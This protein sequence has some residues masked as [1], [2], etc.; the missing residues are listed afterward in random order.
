MYEI[1]QIENKTSTTI[2][3]KRIKHLK[4]LFTTQNKINSPLWYFSTIK[5]RKSNPTFIRGFVID[6]DNKRIPET[7]NIYEHFI[8]KTH[9]NNWRIIVPFDRNYRFTNASDYKNAYMDMLCKIFEPELLSVKDLIDQKYIDKSTIS[10]S[11]AF[12]VRPQENELIEKEGRLYQPSF[13]SKPIKQ[14]KN[15]AVKFSE[16]RKYEDI[17]ECKKILL[18]MQAFFD[19]YK[20][21]LNWEFIKPT[22][23]QCIFTWHENNHAGDIAFNNPSPNCVANI[24]C[25][26]ESCKEK[27]RE[28]C[29]PYQPLEDVEKG[30]NKVRKITNSTVQY[31]A[32]GIIQGF[33]SIEQVEACGYYEHKTSFAIAC[34]VSNQKFVMIAQ[35]EP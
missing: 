5:D 19:Y 2:K 12:F 18:R 32:M 20:C 26:H 15:E 27:L 7:S 6:W 8:H 33:Y 35:R 22:E 28:A 34:R 23:K 3:Y 21:T 16:R 4:E 14:L 30:T 24:H 13:N 29:D 9:N 1:S 31:L 17:E 25:Y 11:R 10:A